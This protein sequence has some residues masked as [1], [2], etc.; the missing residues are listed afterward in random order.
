VIARVRTPIPL[1]NV[2]VP[3]P[4]SRAISAMVNPSA[5]RH[6]SIVRALNSCGRAPWALR[7]PR[8]RVPETFVFTDIVRST[9]G[10]SPQIC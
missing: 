10:P 4:N 6:K 8:A 5:D 9:S 7:V 3:I 2:L 1:R